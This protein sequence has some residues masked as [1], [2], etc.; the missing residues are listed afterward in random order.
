MRLSFPTEVKLTTHGKCSSQWASKSVGSHVSTSS[1]LEVYRRVA[2]ALAAISIPQDSEAPTNCA[3]QGGPVFTSSHPLLGPQ[4]LICGFN[5][6]WLEN[7]FFFKKQLW[8]YKTY[9]NIFLKSSFFSN[10]DRYYNSLHSM[11][12]ELGTAITL[13]QDI[14]VGSYYEK[15][16]PAGRITLEDSGNIRKQ[17]LNGGRRELLFR[18]SFEGYTGYPVSSSVFASCLSV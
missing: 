9:T 2:C 11:Y 6:L 1:K 3:P 14:P 13:L 18:S 15:L 16:V 12:N 17:S 10:Q 4:V 7:S 5:Q 8:L